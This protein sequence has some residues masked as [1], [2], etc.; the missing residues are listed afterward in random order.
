M[1]TGMLNT[2]NH[3]S[4]GMLYPEIKPKNR[5]SNMKLKKIV[6]KHVNSATTKDFPT[7]PSLV[8]NAEFFPRLGLKDVQKLKIG[9]V[10]NV[11]VVWKT[12]ICQF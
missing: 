2:C 12:T 6:G 9:N 11:R 8:D 10:W 1:A 7:T 3:M 5:K 4:V